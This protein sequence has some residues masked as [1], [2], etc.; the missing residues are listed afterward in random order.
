MYPAVV[1]GL[2]FSPLAAYA[3]G[4]NILFEEKNPNLAKITYVDFILAFWLCLT[5]GPTCNETVLD[6][7]S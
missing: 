7:F 2:C 6:L 3:A 5:A 4:T 1:M